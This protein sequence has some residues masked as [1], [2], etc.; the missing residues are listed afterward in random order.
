[1]QLGT[2]PAGNPG[3]PRNWTMN[4]PVEIEPGKPT[5]RSGKSSGRE[6]FR[7]VLQIVRFN[8]PHYAAGTCAMALSL[9]ALRLVSMPAALRVFT[10]IGALLVAFWTVSSLV[11]SHWVYDRG[12]IYELR[13]ITEALVDVPARWVNLHAG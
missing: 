2:R 5:G 3:G 11:A 1:L 6:G 4:T 8:W 10:W 12:G 13:W 9:A 7:G